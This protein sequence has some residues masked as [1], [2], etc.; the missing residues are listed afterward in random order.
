MHDK[1][2][3]LLHRSL[4]TLAWID[5][6]QSIFCH[7][8]LQFHRENLS[9]FCR[10]H[11]HFIGFRQHGAGQQI[12]SKIDSFQNANFLI[13]Q[14]NP[15]TWP[16][17][18]IVSERRFQWG[19]IIGFGWEMR[20]LSWKRFYSLFLNCSP[21]DTLLQIFYSVQG[22]M[23]ICRKYFY[24]FLHNL[25]TIYGQ[26]HAKRDLR[27]YAKIVDPDQPLRL[28]RSVWSGSALF[29]NYNTNGTYFCIPPSN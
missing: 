10:W 8:F 24:H 9:C 26:R 21:D 22:Y 17:I 20:K 3:L 5:T 12:R 16:L 7:V 28:R 29:D 2:G 14:P 27:T 13:S 25:K 4:I 15:M 6:T 23:S 19:H 1:L 11:C 18:V